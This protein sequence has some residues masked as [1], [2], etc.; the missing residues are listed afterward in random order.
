MNCSH[1]Q[2]TRRSVLTAAA[3]GLAGCSSLTVETRTSTPGSADAAGAWRMA[4]YDATQ[5][6]FAA[7]G[8]GPT[9]SAAEVWGSSRSL[10]KTDILAS[11]VVEGDRLYVGC[12]VT[13]HALS[14][15]TGDTHWTTDATGTVNKFTPALSDGTLFVVERGEARRLWAYDTDDGSEVWKRDLSVVSSPVVRDG[16][17]YVVT[18]SERGDQVRALQPDD[19]SDVWTRDIGR[20]PGRY[21]TRTSPAVDGETVYM[22][23]TVGDDESDAS[24]RLFALRAEDGEQKWTFDVSGTITRSGAAV[25]DGTVYFGD[26]AG[27]VHAVDTADRTETWSHSTKNQFWTTPA[28]DGDRVYA[29]ANDGTLFAL[30]R[31][32][33]DVDWQAKTD[34]AYANP[35]VTQERVFVGGNTVLGVEAA[36]G[37]VSW[38]FN[39]DSV[40]SSQFTSPVVVGDILAVA[41]CVKEQAGQTIY[42]DYVSVLS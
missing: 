23:T 32:N 4:G 39:Y 15:E 21:E 10:G 11:P 38:R 16:R 40:F 24:G 1:N 17:V 37:D 18:R 6:S 34:L 35:I 29:G 33:G 41:A 3:A 13:V 7:D 14:L 28:V 42:D 36:S 20:R 2:W 25:A 8:S 12:G 5:C 22:A 9:D 26:N 30:G 19:G 31:S 27:V